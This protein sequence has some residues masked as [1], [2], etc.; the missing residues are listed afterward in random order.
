MT[1][2]F[3]IIGKNGDVSETTVRSTDISSIYKK[4]LAKTPSEVSQQTEWVVKHNQKS[5]K[6]CVY[7][8]TTGRAG[9]ENKYEF[10]PPIDNILLFG[11]VAVVSLIDGAI[12]TL[13]SEE[14]DKIYD[15]L[16]GGFDDIDDDDDD[17]EE[18]E[19]EEDETLPRTKSGY[20]R[21]DFVVD[22]DDNVID[23]EE[24]EEEEEEFDDEDTTSDEDANVVLPAT[25][26]PR[27]SKRLANKGSKKTKV[28]SVINNWIDEYTDE[29]SEEEYV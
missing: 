27:S 13:T 14:W 23:D 7:G 4:L 11:K 6:I 12:G 22:D 25:T 16:H 28:E 24:E 21:D 17:D 20:V 9:Q 8:K 15:R 10:P 2:T 26:K 29:L 1:G 3:L 18:E 19:D 5:Y